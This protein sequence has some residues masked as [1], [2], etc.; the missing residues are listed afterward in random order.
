MLHRWN[1]DRLVG[2]G[3]NSHDAILLKSRKGYRAAAWKD[4]RLCHL[5]FPHKGQVQAA[6][7]LVT[8]Q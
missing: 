8:G 7:L 6:I 1:A 3:F 4:T 5:K 2:I